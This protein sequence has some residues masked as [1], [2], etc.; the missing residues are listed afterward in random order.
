MRAWVRY[1]AI[2]YVLVIYICGSMI[3]SLANNTS[4]DVPD[5]LLIF[6]EHQIAFSAGHEIKVI[7]LKSKKVIS[8]GIKTVSYGDFYI[9]KSNNIAWL[10]DDKVYITIR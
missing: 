3:V 6:S 4:S 10:G 7:N 9:V 5:Q 2:V 8:L 1:S